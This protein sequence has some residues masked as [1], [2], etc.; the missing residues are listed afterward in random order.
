MDE[1]ALSLLVIKHS[2]IHALLVRKEKCSKLAIN[3][4]MN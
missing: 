4:E 1:N 3:A 2:L